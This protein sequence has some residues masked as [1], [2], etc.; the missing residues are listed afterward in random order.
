L[1]LVATLAVA[2]IYLL[3][4]DRLMVGPSWWPL[5]ASVVF[6]VPIVAARVRG[7]H[8]LAR[9]LGLALTVLLTAAVGLSALFL[10]TTL[11]RGTT[12]ASTLLV[13]AALIWLANTVVFALWYWEI[14]GGGPNARHHGYC[15]TDFLFPQIAVGGEAARGWCPEFLD[16]LFLA[17]NTSTAFSPTDTMVLSH[18]AKALMMV[19]SLVSLVVIAFLAARAVNTL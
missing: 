10:V 17:F 5:A 2:G 8:L 13:D 9:T 14:D 4:S 16:Y 12:Q 7:L 11:P 15:T 1:A 19:Q 6:L 3:L 18:R